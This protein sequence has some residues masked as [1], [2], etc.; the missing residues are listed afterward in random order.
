MSLQ[1]DTGEISILQSIR[2]KRRVLTRNISVPFE[3][4][5][6]DIYVLTFDDMLSII[7]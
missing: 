5:S 1:G 3:K 2:L 6:F 7:K 4:V